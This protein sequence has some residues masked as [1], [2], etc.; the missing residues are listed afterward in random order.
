MLVDVFTYNEL[1]IINR[2]R[3]RFPESESDLEAVDLVRSEIFQ[4]A[5][6]ADHKSFWAYA[7]EYMYLTGIIDRLRMNYGSRE[8]AL[9]A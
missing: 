4:D 5:M 1:E 9:V 8:P 6:A 3:E 2:C 7:N